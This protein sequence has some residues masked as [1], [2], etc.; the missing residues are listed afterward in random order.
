MR[1]GANA[2]KELL[3][4]HKLGIDEDLIKIMLGQALLLQES[5]ARV[6]NEV[7]PGS[8]TSLKNLAKIQ[9]LHAEAR[10]WLGASE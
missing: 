3:R 7:N 6:L 5:Y 8:K 4:A 9:Q 10:V 2:E 1:E